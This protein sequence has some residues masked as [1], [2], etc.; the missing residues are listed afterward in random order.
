MFVNDLFPRATGKWKL[1]KTKISDRVTI[2]SGSVVLPVKIGT[3]ALIG[4]GSVVTKNVLP[5]QIVK[6]N[7]AC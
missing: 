6:G 5:Y 3:G 2:G 7:P 4:A 1:R